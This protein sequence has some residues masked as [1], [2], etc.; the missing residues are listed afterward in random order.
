MST[1]KMT[2]KVYD[3]LMA[4]FNRQASELYLMRDAFLNHMIR[5]ETPN[6]AQDL[7]GIPAWSK[8]ETACST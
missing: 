1:T 3:K 8:G 4:N 7:K 2:V 5:R 6:L